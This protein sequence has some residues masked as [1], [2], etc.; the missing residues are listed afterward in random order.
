[1]PD[2]KDKLVKLYC[3][4]T[5][6]IFT[7]HVKLLVNDDGITVAAQNNAC[8]E[9]SSAPIC[10]KCMHALNQHF[11]GKPAIYDGDIIRLDL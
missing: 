7:V 6:R 5:G 2:V 11:E 9:Y 3:R 8:D 10:Q 4:A 1:M